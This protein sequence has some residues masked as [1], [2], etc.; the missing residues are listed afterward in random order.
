MQMFKLMN[1][2]LIAVVVTGWSVMATADVTPN[3]LFSDHMVLQQGIAVPVWGAAD[4]G[5]SVTVS[6]AGQAK[7]AVAGDD[8]RWSVRLDPLAVSG[9]GADMIIA[10]KNSVTIHDVL[11][12]EV[13]L[14]SGQ[15]NM[16]YTVG[17]IH[18]SVYVGVNNQEAEI[19]A[20]DHPLIRMYTVDTKL[21]D[22]PRDDSNGQWEV[23]SPRTVAAFSAAAYFFGRDLQPTINE[24]VG[25]LTS[26]Y[27]GSACQAWLPRSVLEG[28]PVLKP[29]LDEY[30]AACAAWTPEKQDADN[31]A[32][33]KYQEAVTA[34]R[35]AG[36][37]PPRS[38][39]SANPHNSALSPT[40]LYNTMIAPIYPYAI[41]GA[42]WYQGESNVASPDTY[43]RLEAALIHK[44]RDLWGEG[45]FPFIFV[46][47][48]NYH[49]PVTEPTDDSKEARLRDQQAT[50][51]ALPNTAMAVTIDIGEA[52]NIH[53]RDK[54]DVGKRLAL[55]AE[56]MVYHQNV[57]SSGP[58]FDSMTIDGGNVRVH[59]D[60]A[61]GG[62]VGK[63]GA[64]QGFALAGADHQWFWADAKIDGDSVVVSSAS[65]PKPAL[66]SYAWAD[67]PPAT[68]YNGAG[69]P[70]R[71]F[72]S[73]VAG[74]GK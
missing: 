8:G 15:S 34:A 16:V 9:T 23:C 22:K 14:C 43:G 44:L 54:Q 33:K 6:F 47:L 42:L 70:A 2:A 17:N 59:F 37:K 58:V 19:A 66:V 18:K 60:H 67:D 61:D 41:R 63:D 69:L 29:V 40:L 13:W 32:R 48:P 38:F 56:A 52:D 1:G 11:V 31:A 46:Q 27:G 49:A 71:P 5:E 20:A 55:I 68:L 7:T 53:P 36:T 74:A 26:A 64:L 51:L 21:A 25:L 4:P 45:D 73:D 72:R 57:V 24:P 62:L 3:H 65:V 35:A 28:D 30:D 39:R 10:G 50:G 12:G